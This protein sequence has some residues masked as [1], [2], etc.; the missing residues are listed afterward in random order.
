[1]TEKALKGIVLALG[2]LAIAAAI[3]MVARGPGPLGRERDA[4]GHGDYVLQAT[5][6]TT[7]T[8]AA[9]RGHPSAVFFGF[10]HC[11]DVCPTTLGEI[12]TWQEE[13][14]DAAK[15]LRFWFVTVD[16][17]RDTVD[18]LRDYLSWTAGV[19]G[20]AGTR[21]EVDEAI[22]AFRIYARKVPLSD[23]SYT[24]D[25][26]PFVMLFDRNGSFVQTIGYREETAT[27]V[28]KL[29]ALVAAG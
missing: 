3:W 28:D 21:A 15:D 27:A 26:T 10:T 8:E 16:P 1:M 29:R 7:F 12:G 14:G 11:P 17:E 23:G 2:A 13:L 25:H 20:A 9:L 6:G 24:M 18:Q 22:A 4:I 19:T 5:D